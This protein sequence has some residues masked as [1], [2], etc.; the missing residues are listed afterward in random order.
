MTDYALTQQNSDSFSFR[1]VAEIFAYYSPTIRRQ[2]LIYLAVSIL[3]GILLLIPGSDNVRCGFFSL[4]WAILQWMWYLSPLS[5][6]GKGKSGIVDRLLPVKASEKLTFFIIYFVVIIPLV[7]FTLPICAELSIVDSL[8]PEMP[9]FKSLLNLQLHSSWIIKVINILGGITSS[10]VC[11]YVIL[12]VRH[13]KMI[14]GILASFAVQI[15]LGILG[16][17]YA[18]YEMAAEAF[19]KGF[20]DGL[21]G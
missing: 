3:F 2:L 5:M 11:L 19:K 21:A 12:R 7:A 17:I 18:G 14:S 20:E 1:R 8:G 13:N 16:A 9:H 10:L 15:V 4:V 6:A